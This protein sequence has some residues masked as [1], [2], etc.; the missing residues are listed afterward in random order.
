MK[1]NKYLV[2]LCLLFN[3]IILP[4]QSP[5]VLLQDKLTGLSPNEEN[6]SPAQ[7]KSINEFWR[8]FKEIR[9]KEMSLDRL[10]GNAQF[11][12]L[13][14]SSEGDEILRIN[15]GI[16]LQKGSYPQ[17]FEFSTML[18]ILID[19]GE[20][21]ENLSNLRISYDRFFNTKNGFNM[22]G[23]SFIN[24]RSDAYLG[25]NQRY[26]IGAGIIFAHWKKKLFPASQAM[27]D[28]YCEEKISFH[29]M[30]NQV[31]V[32]DVKN[33]VPIEARGITP[34]DFDVL[35][36]AQKRISNTIIK[37]HT[38]LRVGF[39]IGA[40]YEIESSSHSDS[41]M[42]A[43]GMRFFSH[44]FTTVNKFRWEFRPT[45]DL[46]FSEGVRLK[47]RPFFK[48]PMPWEWETNVDGKKE[49]DARLDFPI[50]LTFALSDK[51]SMSINYVLYYDNAP[52]SLLLEEKDVNGNPL[53]LTAN[54]E[55]HYYAFQVNYAFR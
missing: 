3:A 13:G 32:C 9:D 12:F 26:E 45:F 31:V 19:N 49:I 22:E 25:L 11:G 1:M 17:D 41:L 33:C 18:N 16:S 55:H 46:R 39:M 4:A 35:N 34:S 6:L 40:F 42:T 10:K 30:D 7:V 14:N 20:L 48:L 29:S 8:I 51:F 15:G 38:P 28:S 47:I 52:P 21:Q 36:Q 24:R 27:Y 50:S 5:L 23:Y 53:Y 54:K 43:E 44:D 37:D 2:L